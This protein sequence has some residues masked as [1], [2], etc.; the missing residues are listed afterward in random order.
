MRIGVVGASGFVGQRAIEM[1]QASGDEVRPIVRSAASCDR[2]AQLDLDCR[3]AN[4][5]DRGSLAAAF[6]GCEVIIHSILGSPGLIRGSIT[7]TYQAAQRAGVRRIVYLSSMIVHTSAPA[8]GTT[9]ATPPITAQPFPTHNA[10]IDAE[11]R[12]WQLRQQGDVE[13][14]IFRPGIVFG[15]RSRWVTGLAAS[16]CEGRAY[17]LDRG[18]G[19]CNTVYIDNLIHAIRLAMTVPAA[20]GEA[21]F[22]GDRERVTWLDFYQPFADALGVDLAQLPA[23]TVPTFTHS[24]SELAIDSVRNSAIVQQAIALI[25]TALKQQFKRSSTTSPIPP[26]QPA[27]NAAPPV[28]EEMM[29]IL[30]RS[31]Y[32][33]PFTKAEQILGYQPIVSF[34]E[35]CDRS[36]A[37]L[38]ELDR[39][40]SL[41]RS[42]VAGYST[43]DRASAGDR[44]G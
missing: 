25:P 16:L 11:R 14:T 5:F 26:T 7:P 42:P 37:W 44:S 28:V 20:D 36:I 3:I 33:L 22:V 31:P 24:R 34:P 13:V 6:A 40:R 35:G 30:Q 12:L 19:I 17:L 9:E 10:K 41:L 2:L 8:V 21:F 43:D 23:V 18:S 4:C 32:Q 29:S 39:F 15:P 38:A 1:L 27:P